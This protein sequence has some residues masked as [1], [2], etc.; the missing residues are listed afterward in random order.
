MRHVSVSS[1][2]RARIRQLFEEGLTQREVLRRAEMDA[3]S[4]FD[5]LSLDSL[6]RD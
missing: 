5:A 1:H 3:F 6:T 4:D 2:M